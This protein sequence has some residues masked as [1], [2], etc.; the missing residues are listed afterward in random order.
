MNACSSVQLAKKKFP[1]LGEMSAGAW[2][3]TVERVELERLNAQKF[4]S[5]RAISLLEDSIQTRANQLIQD[6]VTA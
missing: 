1:T 4:C 2:L 5:L 3:F 6:G